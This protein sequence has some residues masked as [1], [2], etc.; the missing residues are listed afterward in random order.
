MFRPF[1]CSSENLDVEI[2][3]SLV[4]WAV[5]NMGESCDLKNLHNNVA[6]A[7]QMLDVH[8]AMLLA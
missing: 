7:G 3:L 2:S 4:S 6:E 8:L 1:A 5:S